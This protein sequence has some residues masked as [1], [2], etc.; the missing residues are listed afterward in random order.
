MPK[1]E[2]QKRR[3]SEPPQ[4]K[5]G[6]WTP[7]SD[8]KR[9]FNPASDEEF[10]SEHPIGY[11]FLVFF[12][13]IVLLLP[14]ALYG[15]YSFRIS[16]DGNGWMVLGWIGAFIVGIGLFNY[17]AIIIHQFLGHLVSILSFL[18]GGILIAISL[19]FL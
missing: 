12:A 9:Y 15:I 6:R 16:P 4:S 11:F 3:R 10:K 19:H 17:V 7:P 1:S 2:R 18:I 14:L 8:W 13:I 5:V